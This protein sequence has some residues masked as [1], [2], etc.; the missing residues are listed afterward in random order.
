MDQSILEGLKMIVELFDS[1]TYAALFGGIAY[2]LIVEIL[3]KVIPWVGG[4]FL[5]RLIVK[6]IPS[7]KINIEKIGEEL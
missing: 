7:G 1:V 5:L 6:A 2:L 4:Y 3:A